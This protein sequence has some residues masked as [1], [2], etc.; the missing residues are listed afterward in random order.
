MSVDPARI[1]VVEDSPTIREI[2]VSVLQRAGHEVITAGDGEEGVAL[3]EARRPDLVLL[4]VHMPRLDGWQ[5]LERIRAWSDKPVLVLSGHDER[6]VRIRMLMQGADDYMVKPAHPGE[7]LA[8]I[9]ALLR[10]YRR[11]P[12][13]AE[14][15]VHDDG[16]VRVDL[17]ARHA[18]IHGRTVQ[19]SP[20]EFKLLALLVHRAGDVLTKEDLMQGVWA[21]TTSGPADSVKLYVGYLRRKLG[22][23]TDQALIETV[24]GVGYRW[25]RPPL[26]DAGELDRRQV[27]VPGA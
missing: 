23:H 3:F 19:L 1:L 25:V 7:L 6:T 16:L 27:R 26:A 14:A 13:G 10:R 9:A 2:L 12:V 18:Q 11:A 8:R 24:R 21:D 5:V 22:E 20:L 4:D 15:S 17:C